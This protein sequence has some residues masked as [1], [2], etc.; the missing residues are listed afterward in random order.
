MLQNVEAAATRQVDVYENWAIIIFTLQMPTVCRIGLHT[1]VLGSLGHTHVPLIIGLPILA[2]E[3]LYA[4]KLLRH[5][6]AL[7][8]RHSCFDA[9]HTSLSDA[10]LRVRLQYLIFKYAHHAP[11]WQFVLWARQLGLIGISTFFQV[12][13]DDESEMVYTEAYASLG[14]L[15]A[16]L[17]LHWRTWP[18]MFRYQNVAET[19]LSLCSIVAV[20]ASMVCYHP[21]HP[22]VS[23]H[24]L[25]YAF[26]QTALIGMLL[27]P[28]FIFGVWLTV[29][30]QR[31]VV[32]LSMNGLSS[33]SD[34]LL[35]LSCVHPERGPPLPLL[36]EISINRTDVVERNVV[37]RA[38]L[39]ASA[40]LR[41][42]REKLVRAVLP[43]D[44]TATAAA[45]GV[46]VDTRYTASAA[47]LLLGKPSDATL[48][49]A[50]HLGLS[51]EELASRMCNGV[52]AIVDECEAQLGLGTRRVCDDMR[53]LEHVLF[54]P[55]MDHEGSYDQARAGQTLVLPQ[56]PERRARAP[57]ARARRRTALVHDRGLQVDQRAVTRHRTYRS[58]PVYANFD[59]A[60]LDLT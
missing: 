16:T 33:V 27:G 20:L 22:S 12:Y 26:F 37:F 40:E 48:D 9:R 21:N 38:P 41:A 4:G 54:E 7:Q 28:V 18:Y 59:L 60:G 58:L 57:L 35:R 46:N 14:V 36:G 32:R 3:F 49:I 42:L 23:H 39:F 6:R 45:S 30:G 47:D 19:I 17:L 25:S 44:G 11:Y 50:S 53:L 34:P 29:G 55:A 43:T 10:R 8:G 13:S 56:A 52:Q 24:K 2:F 15:I 5:V 31:Y 51:S 1:L